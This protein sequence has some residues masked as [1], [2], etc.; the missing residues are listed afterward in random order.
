MLCFSH[1][2]KRFDGLVPVCLCKIRGSNIYNLRFQFETSSF[3]LIKAVLGFFESY[4][5]ALIPFA[6][7]RLFVQ[8]VFHGVID[9]IQLRVMLA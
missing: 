2:D 8:E 1:A 3:W 6:L 9:M 4:S 5:F 7:A